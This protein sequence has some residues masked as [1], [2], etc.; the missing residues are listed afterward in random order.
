MKN[1]SMAEKS[2]L[3]EFAVKGST[4]S[5]AIA[6]K[7][8]EADHMR[9]APIERISPSTISHHDMRMPFV[10]HPHSRYCLKLFKG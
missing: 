10:Q 2:V 1:I 7:T 3:N 6:E 5:S 8:V 9:A 4:S